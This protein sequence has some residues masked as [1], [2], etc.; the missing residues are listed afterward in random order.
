MEKYRK[1]TKILILTSTL[2]LIFITAICSATQIDESQIIKDST[3]K[4][5]QDFILD[6]S[7]DT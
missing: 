3:A 2:Y 1:V 7:W 4:M 5:L 6:L